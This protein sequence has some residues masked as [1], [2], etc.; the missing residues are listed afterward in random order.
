MGT[1]PLTPAERLPCSER[2]SAPS[3]PAAAFAAARSSSAACAPPPTPPTTALLDG[4]RPAA[5]APSSS[6][7]PPPTSRSHASAAA[8]TARACALSISAADAAGDISRER[9]LATSSRARSPGNRPLVRTAVRRRHVVRSDA[10]GPEPAERTSRPPPPE[11]ESDPDPGAGSGAERTN[12]TS[13]TNDDAVGNEAPLFIRAPPASAGVG[14]SATEDPSGAS[15][16]FAPFPPSSS[17]SSSPS[18]YSSSSSPLAA[19]AASHLGSTAMIC[20]HA[21]SSSSG[22]SP[23]GSARTRSGNRLASCPSGRRAPA[24]LARTR[25]SMS[26][27]LRS[28][29]SRWIHAFPS[30]S[31]PHGLPTRRTR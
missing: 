12:G 22:S 3:A 11:S 15:D 26:P 21:S 25:L 17:S 29:G 13:N 19:P 2:C 1:P 4:V 16:L 30:H 5:P 24:R 20:T 18:S 14:F 23:S 27:R 8:A 7:R 28:M 6:P 31:G 10:R 9:S